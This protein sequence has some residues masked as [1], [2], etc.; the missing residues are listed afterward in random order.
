V[1]SGSLSAQTPT[2]SVGF[3]FRPGD[4]VWAYGRDSGGINQQESV[5]S[6]RRA[7]EE[8]CREHSVAVVH[9]FSDE[10]RPGSTTVGRDAL[11]NLLYLSKQKP[12]PVEGIIFWSL[13]R[14]A[15]DQLD[16]QFI[17]IDLRRR[18]YIIHSM[19]DDIP[20]GEFAPVIEALIDWKNE[21]FLKD[22]SR[23]VQRGLA[24]LA[25]KG[26][27]PG[28]FPPRGYN[29]E[30]VQI[31]V[32]RDGQPHI[33]SQWV[34]DP[35]LAPRVTRAWEM[36]AAG[37]S[38]EQI[39]EA[40]HVMGTLG[41]Y[42]T[43]FRNTTYLGVRKCGDLEVENA[44]E[45][46]VS[47]ELW[48]AVQATLRKRPAK[49]ERW[50][51]GKRHP[52]RQ[53]TPY[54]LSGIAY[55][56]ECGAAMVSGADNM[57][58]H[59]RSPWPYY[60]CGRK[61][62]EGW[63]SCPTGKIGARKPERVVLQTVTKRVLT[64]DSVAALVA[65]VHD[66]MDRDAPTVRGQIQETERQIARV[67][68][69]ID[70]LLDVT[71]RFGADSAGPRLAEREAERA[72]LQARLQQLVAQQ[73]DRA[74]AISLEMV[75]DMLTKMHGTLTDGDLQAKRALLSKVVARIDMGREGAGLSY[76]FPL[77]E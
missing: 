43:M 42:V 29:A 40:T 28:G 55:C 49:G 24:D 50:P 61:K 26:Y 27:A 20:T 19:I 38:Y 74:P 46:L 4:R 34:P 6:Q 18:G 13:A 68:E 73:E 10:A 59:R 65:E 54:L 63:S 45:P 12:Q 9:F 53:N 51:K 66:L 62:R 2:Y 67:E 60:L 71:E 70:N 31:D 69:A 52:M 47:R 36:R 1:L 57:N 23:N 25:R 76:T 77:R 56:A 5:S 3:P 39:H 41:S 15:R 22:L 72:Q 33:V 17:K 64:P 58:G 30:K 37:A 44:H 14:L 8:I 21:R 35:E 16:S 11:E 7:I 32:K 48:D 75:Q